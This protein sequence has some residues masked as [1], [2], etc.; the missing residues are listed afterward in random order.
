MGQVLPSCARTTAAVRGRI[1]RRQ[2]SL[3]AL[4]KRHRR[5]PKTV[6]KWRRRPPTADAPSGPKPASTGRSAEQEARAVAFGQHPL[7]PLDG[8]LDAL[9]ETSPHRSRTAL[10]RCFQRHGVR[11]VPLN[12]EG[13]S[14][15]KKKGK[16]YP[17]GYR[18]VAFAAGRP[19]E[20]RPYLL[21]ALDFRQQS[22]LCRTAA[23][24]PAPRACLRRTFCGGCWK[25]GPTKPLPG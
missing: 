25:S 11:R 3:Q 10:P 16:A 2:Q 19:E 6:A 13:K 20:G 23:P 24:R 5:K 9:P 12:E 15:P 14:V 18:P 8:G 17:L 7:L 1:Q 21:V 22:R 4:A